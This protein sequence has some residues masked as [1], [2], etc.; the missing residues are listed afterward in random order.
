MPHIPPKQVPREFV[1]AA[2]S[3]T[4]WDL[5]DQVLYDLFRAHPEHKEDQ[6]IIAKIWLLGRAYAA[7]IERGKTRAD[8]A[9]RVFYETALAPAIRNSSID[10]WFQEIRNAAP[11]DLPVHL[12]VHRRV[13]DL[14]KQISGIERRSLA[15]QYLHFHFPERFFIHHSR[16][17]TALSQLTKRSGPPPEHLGLNNPD[18]RYARFF[19]RAESLRGQLS[20]L[21]GRQITPRQLD[22]VLLSYTP[23]KKRKR[24][25][26]SKP[27]P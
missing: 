27:L 1:E 10:A 13:M 14:F 21:L 3:Q 22:N 26:P 15:S 18:H 5:G 24:N 17:V 12:E 23:P 7:P 9:G 6:V 19:L 25:R 2:V 4:L 16:A 20:T 11:Y 8:P